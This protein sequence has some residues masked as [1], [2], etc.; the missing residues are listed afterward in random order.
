MT[1]VLKAGHPGVLFVYMFVLF[2]IGVQR[3]F[4]MCHICTM[5]FHVH[6]YTCTC[7]IIVLYMSMSRD[8]WLV[9]PHYD[10]V[11]VHV[12]IHVHVNLSDKHDTLK[13]TSTQVFWGHS[14]DG[15]AVISDFIHRCYKGI[16][17]NIAMMVDDADSSQHAVGPI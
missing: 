6:V 7:T 5:Y 14:T 17:E 15:S 8:R 16:V 1:P 13:L 9:W 2:S 11:N 12:Y 10:S 3:F 4:S